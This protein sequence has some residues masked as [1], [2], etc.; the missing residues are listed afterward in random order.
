MKNDLANRIT[1]V[2]FL[3]L[4]LSACSPR[5]SFIPEREDLP[6]AVIDQPYFHKINIIGGRVIKMKES[7]SGKIE[8][9]DSGLFM[10]NCRLPERVIVPETTM[11]LDGNCVEIKGTPVRTGTVK[12]TLSGGLHGNMFVSY[13]RFKKSYLIKIVADQKK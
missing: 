10:E 2:T 3:L 13:G 9:S 12:V 5:A 8:P 6:D 11:L 1:F 4:T 7:V